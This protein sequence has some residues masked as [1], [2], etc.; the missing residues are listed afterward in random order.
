M[1]KKQKQIAFW[2]FMSLI[3]IGCTLI[4]IFAII[5][6]DWQGKVNQYYHRILTTL[7]SVLSPTL[8]IGVMTKI[9]ISKMLEKQQKENLDKQ[10]NSKLLENGLLKHLESNLDILGVKL[11][12][13][14]KELY[15]DKKGWKVRYWK[16]KIIID[17]SD[18]KVIDNEEDLW[19]QLKYVF[20]IIQEIARKGELC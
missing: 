11:P 14:K 15:N 17:F 7:S 18:V 5:S 2:T 3:S 19:K 16:K 10:I 4:F 20:G 13:D 12:K 6:A 8:I 9:I 1:N